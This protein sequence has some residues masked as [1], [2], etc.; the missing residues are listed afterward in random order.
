[1][2]FSKTLFGH[3]T[4]AQKNKGSGSLLFCTIKIREEH[5]REKFLHVCGFCYKYLN[6]DG[7]LG[8]MGGVENDYEK[9]YKRFVACNPKLWGLEIGS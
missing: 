3:I 7:H 6:V 5:E 1:M 4:Y 9:V 2:R 8:F